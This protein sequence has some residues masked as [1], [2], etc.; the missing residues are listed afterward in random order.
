MYRRVSPG[1]PD[2]VTDVL[3]SEYTPLPGVIVGAVVARAGR[4]ARIHEIAIS[5][6]NIAVLRR[7][8]ISHRKAKQRLSK[9]CQNDSS[10]TKET[11][12]RRDVFI[13]ASSGNTEEADYWLKWGNREDACVTAKTKIR[14]K[15]SAVN[16]AYFEYIHIAEKV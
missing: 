10:S 11:F 14:G 6:A 16:V 12:R 5:P 4:T 9:P 1:S 2:M 3:R 7:F 8:E 15:Q 13:L